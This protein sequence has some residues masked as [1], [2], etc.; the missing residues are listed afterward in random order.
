LILENSNQKKR[1]KIIAATATMSETYNQQTK[2]LYLRDAIRFPSQ[3]PRLDASFYSG[4]TDNISRFIFGLSAHNKSRIDTILDLIKYLKEILIPL[5]EKPEKILDI[6]IGIGDVK[7]ARELIKDYSTILSYH[8]RKSD[9]EAINTSIKTMV[10]PELI[11]NN[12]KTL[13]FKTLTGDVNFSDVKD[14]LRSIENEEKI[15]LITATK[16][17]SHGVDLNNLNIMIFQGMPRNNAEYIQALSRIGRKYPGLAIISFNT[18]YE[19]D[20]SYY[21][22][23]NKFHEFK[24]MLVEAVPLSRWAKFSIEPTLGGIF[25]GTI[26]CHFDRLVFEKFGREIHMSQWFKEAL[27]NEESNRIINEDSVKNF[28]LKSYGLDKYPN[29]H[30]EEEIT[31]K[32]TYFFD[33]IEESERNV[34]LKNLL[35]RKQIKVM[36]SLRDIEKQVKITALEDNSIVASCRGT[37]ETSDYDDADEGGILQ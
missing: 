24:D 29:E 36:S 6:N 28:I 15:D 18:T 3:G 12:L 35:E 16:F 2:E 8:I 31:N 4:I 9:G 23:F 11:K 5:E 10:N 17:I 37:Y 33:C 22:Y 32:I 13:E 26:L 30:F 34:Y 7:D 21:Q 27:N 19:R 14:I 20:K 25:M 1:L